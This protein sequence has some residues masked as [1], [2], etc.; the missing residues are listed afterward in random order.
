MYRLFVALFSLKTC[1]LSAAG[2]ALAMVYE[3]VVDAILKL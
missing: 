1:K 2:A 3:Y